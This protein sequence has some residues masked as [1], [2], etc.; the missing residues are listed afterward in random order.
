MKSPLSLR[1]VTA[2]TSHSYNK[3]ANTVFRIYTHGIVL[4]AR[5][6]NSVTRII[7]YMCVVVSTIL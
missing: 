1:K 4:P 5:A 2:H 6:E 3:H 7:L